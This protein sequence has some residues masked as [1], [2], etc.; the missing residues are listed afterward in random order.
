MFDLRH[1][2]LPLLLS[3]QLLPRFTFYLLLFF[4]VLRRIRLLKQQVD[5]LAN[6]FQVF[7]H[8]Q[9]SIATVIFVPIQCYETPD[10][11]LKLP[12]HHGDIIAVERIGAIFNEIAL[13]SPA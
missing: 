4:F 7:H 2:L 11:I 10:G 3:L 5:V 6:I 9:H 12:F 8:A 13:R 1:S